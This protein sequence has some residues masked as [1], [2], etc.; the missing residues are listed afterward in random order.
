[1]PRFMPIGPLP[2]GLPDVMEPAF[3]ASEHWIRGFTAIEHQ[4]AHWIRGFTAI[5]RQSAHWIRALI[6]VSSRSSWRGPVG[7]YRVD[8]ST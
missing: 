5:E 2:D 8:I 3:T 6:R 1:M 4:N 7:P